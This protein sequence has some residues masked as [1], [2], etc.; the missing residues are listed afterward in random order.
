MSTDERVKKFLESVL[1]QVQKFLMERRL[2]R[3]VLVII[4]IDSN[5]TIERWEFKIDC[6]HSIDAEK[7]VDVNLKE[8][9]QGIRD[10]IR[11]ITASITYLPL[12][13]DPV[14]FDILFFTDKDTELPVDFHDTTPHLIPCAEE[15]KLRSFNTKIHN[16]KASVA[17]KQCE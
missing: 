13:S 4:K 12:I 7:N 16:L 9:Q 17:Y 2:H 5:E 6:D 11:Q 14:S 8:I 1:G 3:I 15:V 10:V